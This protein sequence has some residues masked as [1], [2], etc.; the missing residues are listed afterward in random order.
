MEFNQSRHGII[1]KLLALCNGFEWDRG[2]IGKNWIGHKVSDKEAEQ[3][4]VGIPLRFADDPKHSQIEQRYLALG[5]TRENRLIFLAFTIRGI[6][7]R[8]ISA[9]DMND[10]DKRDYA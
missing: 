1:A 2:N 5:K 9:R 4:F 10:K 7:I 3:V 6:K 8:I